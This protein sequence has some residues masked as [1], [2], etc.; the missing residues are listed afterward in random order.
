MADDDMR[1]VTRFDTDAD[2]NKAVETLTLRGIGALVE[3]SGAAGEP[4]GYSVLV[5]LPDIERACEALGVE[6]PVEATAELEATRTRRFADWVYVL[7]IFAVAA[8]V[9]PLMAF[10]LSYKLAGG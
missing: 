8:A 5:V 6:A 10:F 7:I 4:Q 9:I 2:A 1:E 3:R